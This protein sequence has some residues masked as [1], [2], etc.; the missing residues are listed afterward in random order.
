MESLNESVAPLGL[1]VAIPTLGRPILEQT[2]G[3][4]ARAAGAESLE[5]LVVGRIPDEGLAG[6]VRDLGR[7]FRRF[8]H[9]PLAFETGDSSRKKNAGLEAA[10]TGVVAFLDDDV[11]V[12]P[13]WPLR[14]LEPFADPAV[15]MVSGPS[16]VPD[17]LPLMPRLAGLAL[18]SRAAGYVSERYRLGAAGA[19]DIRWSRIIGCNMAFRRSV[20]AGL[21]GFDPRFWPGEEMVAAFGVAKQGRR[22]V[23]QS[24]AW[25]HH[26]PRATLAGF[27]RQIHGYGATRIRLIRAGLECEP[28]TL[29]PAVM[30]AGALVLAAAACWSGLAARVLAAAVALYLLAAIGLMLEMVFRTR[31]PADVLLLALIPVMHLVYGLAEWREFLRPN[32]DLSG[33]V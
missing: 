2:L 27:V 12:S 31:R 5:V 19:R 15:G 10:R 29:A 11:V 24:A 25:V 20:L 7:R 30:V 18:A 8:E 22:I 16:L 21:G 32:Q 26:Y 17:D 13:D 14:I 33:R 28:T 1:S 4:L 9:F 6:R 3:S 23:F